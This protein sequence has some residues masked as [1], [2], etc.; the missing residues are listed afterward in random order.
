LDYHKVAQTVAW[1]AT[2]IAACRLTDCIVGYQNVREQ[3]IS[4]CLGCDIL[5][6]N[7]MCYNNAAFPTFY[8]RYHKA[9]P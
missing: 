8:T 4:G 9:E 1:Q 5:E 2:F 6:K 3:S 7:Y